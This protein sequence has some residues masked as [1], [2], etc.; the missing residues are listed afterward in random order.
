MRIIGLVGTKGAGKDTFADALGLPKFSF[1]A[2]IKEACCAI[3]MLDDEA[4][5]D[6]HLKETVDPRWGISPRSMLQT[7]G[8]E[9]VR[10]HFGDDH[11]I[12]H[13]SMRLEQCSEDDIVITDV[14]FR[15]EA[16][17]VKARGGELIR[18]VRPALNVDD[19]HSSE[20]A[21]RNI[22]CDA[23]ILNDGSK[24][25][26]CKQATSFRKKNMSSV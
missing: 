20:T 8:T 9:C 11:W 4:F 2:P 19:A 26:L 17:F 15:D 10:G 13:M 22:A 6:R 25:Q 5:E 24:E 12:R 3:F 18:I 21:I 23:I 14:R 16:D 7:L 1:A